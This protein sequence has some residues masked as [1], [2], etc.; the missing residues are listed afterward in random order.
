ML[1]ILKIG[2]AIDNRDIT[3][4]HLKFVMEKVAADVGSTA[5]VWQAPQ[6]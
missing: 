3:P 4:T 6:Q 1:T 2:M 5:D